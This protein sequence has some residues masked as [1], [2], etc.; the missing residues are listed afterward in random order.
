MIV[1]RALRIRALRILFALALL[2][3]QHAALAHQ[4]WH[5][6]D[7]ATLPAQSQLC[8]HHQALGTV[9]GAVDCP[10]IQASDEAP[11]EFLC[12]SVDLPAASTPGLAPSSRGPPTRL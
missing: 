10:I 4:I 5:L 11:T 9:V 2:N 12:R 7:H 6:G 1:V 8:D 3:A